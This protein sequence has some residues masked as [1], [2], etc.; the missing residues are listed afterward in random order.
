MLEEFNFKVA[1]K[2]DYCN[3]RI[4][5]WMSDFRHKIEKSQILLFCQMSALANRSK[6]KTMSD[7]FRDKTY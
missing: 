5:K 4:I 1:V 2:C 3:K 6:R 7:L